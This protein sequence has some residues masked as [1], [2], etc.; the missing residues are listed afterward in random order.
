M[1]QE[2]EDQSRLE[3]VADNSAERTAETNRD[4]QISLE[5]AR[6]AAAGEGPNATGSSAS[7]TAE[8]HVPSNSDP[9][10]SDL[11]SAR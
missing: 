8:E 2:H 5:E 10:S 3:E 9:D 11:P 1:N 6:N 4:P 7:S